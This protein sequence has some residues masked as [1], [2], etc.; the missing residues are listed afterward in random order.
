MG[1]REQEERMD[2][3]RS[4]RQDGRDGEEYSIKWRHTWEGNAKVNEQAASD[5]N[6]LQ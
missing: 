6:S 1:R 2:G 5:S 3:D 4:E